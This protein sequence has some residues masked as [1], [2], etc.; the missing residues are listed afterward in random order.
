MNLLEC[1][2]NIIYSLLWGWMEE[3]AVG[4]VWLSELLAPLSTAL[5]TVSMYWYGESHH[6][7]YFCTLVH[8]HSLQVIPPDAG[9]RLV[10]AFKLHCV[11]TLC[12]LQCDIRWHH[13]PLPTMLAYVC[14]DITWHHH[15]SHELAEPAV[16]WHH[17]MSSSTSLLSI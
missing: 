16:L 10:S 9:E 7:T 17:V 11:C 14:T 8:T 12:V 2:Y 5:N 1:V 15:A 6:N 3:K 4:F 13:F